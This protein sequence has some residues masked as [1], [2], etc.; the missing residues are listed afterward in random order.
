MFR[1]DRLDELVKERGK[2]KN[3]L[4][5]RLGHSGRYLNDAKKQN[6]K[7]DGDAVY[8][9]AAELGT[10][11]EYLMGTTDKKSAPPIDDETLILASRIKNLDSR[12]RGAVLAVLNYEESLVPSPAAV[13]SKLI[14]LFGQSLAAGPGEPDFGNPFEEYEVP[15]DS[16]AEIAFRIHGDSMEPYFHDQEV[17]LAVKRQPQ[18]GEVGAFLVDGEYKVKQFAIDHTNNVYLFALNRKREDTD[19]ILW[20]REEH[21]VYCLGTVLMDK[22][23]PMPQ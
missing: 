8:I 10:S 4:S 13:P 11:Y 22:R 17:V 18:V 9:L 14:P 16:K 20:A 2:T 19:Q 21:T 23:P 3:Y 1:Y 15:A 5:E 12:S 6:T 7:L